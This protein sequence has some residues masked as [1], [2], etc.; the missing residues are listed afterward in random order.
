MRVKQENVRLV[1]S[2]HLPA[3]S[4]HR[5]Q[6]SEEMRRCVQNTSAKLNDADSCCGK[7]KKNKCPWQH[8]L[9][10]T[11][12]HAVPLALKG[13]TAVFG[14]GTGVSLSPWLPETE[15]II[16]HK[17][18]PVNTLPKIA[19]IPNLYIIIQTLF[20]EAR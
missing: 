8:L 3:C 19:F 11:L 4:L 2:N 12:S 9:S 1:N 13:L 10:H 17:K 14:M 6:G 15:K 7:R 5:E 16:P 18:S 20:G